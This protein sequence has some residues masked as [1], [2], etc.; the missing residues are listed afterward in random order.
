LRAA[1]ACAHN[2]MQTPAAWR[3]LK[4][5]QGYDLVQR[6][7]MLFIA[8]GLIYDYF[9]SNQFFVSFKGFTFLTKMLTT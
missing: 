2:A 9:R 8:V 6:Q 5:A 1:A 3:Y 7:Q 4:F